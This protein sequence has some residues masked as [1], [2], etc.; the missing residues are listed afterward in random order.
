MKSR[1]SPQKNTTR[2]RVS[3]QNKTQSGNGN[4]MPIP[5]I[6][7]KTIIGL[8]VILASAFLLFFNLGHYALWDDESETALGAQGVLATG[9]TTAV[10]G[11]N[12]QARRGGIN[13]IHLHDRVT[14]PLPTYLMAA[15]FRVFGVSTFAARLPVALCGLL[16]IGLILWWMWKSDA[17]LQTWLLMAVAILG[18]VSF[19]LYFRQAR[20]YGV[21]LSLA[22]FLV[23]FYLNWKPTRRHAACFSMAAGFL[24]MC[25]PIA[26]AQAAAV[27]GLDYL[28]FNRQQKIFQLRTLPFL[29]G[30]ATVMVV[31]TLLVWNPLATKAKGYLDTVTLQDRLTLLYWYFRDI[32]AAEFLVGLLVVAAPFAYLLSR[33]KWILR[34]LT[35]IVVTVAVTSMVSY[36]NLTQTSV[37]D[38]RYTI[39]VIPLG[40]ML[41]VL[42]IQGIVPRNTG[43]AVA[44]AVVAFWTNLLHGAV[45]RPSKVSSSLKKFTGELLHPVPEPYTP[46]A[47][48]IRNEVPPDASI[49]VF[50][51]YMAYPLMFYAPQAIY[52]WQIPNDS[53][54][55]FSALPAIHFQGKVMPDYIIVFGPALQ[56]LLPYF[57][58]WHETRGVSYQR[59]ANI[60]VFWKDLY[61]PEL[62]WRT[63]VPVTGFNPD[64]D[65]VNILKRQN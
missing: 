46:V 2:S 8:A 60:P 7:Q 45:F 18:N 9:D 58:H 43:W 55:Q 5:T 31:A 65:G 35:A 54:P 11:H 17:I 34:C 30:P 62:F 15:S 28:L 19:F 37:A 33:N 49:V 13:L 44:I 64:R 20:Y 63:F 40:I 52:A 25:H 16:T 51:D 10:I 23:Y 14:P 50:P 32:N 1:S 41:G 48:W 36:Q 42:T 12:I 3:E 59:V 38:I 27:I 57:N 47:T 24:F 26:F 53:D 22:V 6:R 61:R 29:A 56:S 39:A 21:A 4:K